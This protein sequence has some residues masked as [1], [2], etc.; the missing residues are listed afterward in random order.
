MYIAPHLT[1]VITNK[2][3][4]WIGAWYFGWVFIA[5]V[6]SSFSVIMALFPKELPRAAVRRRIATEKERRKNAS[7]LDL[8]EKDV[9][10]ETS[11]KDFFLTFKRLLKN[12]LYMYNNLA[13]TFYVFGFMPFWIFSPKLI[14]TLF[15]QSSSASSLFTG[16]F[17]LVASA[18]GILV[19]GFVITKFK[20]RARY[21]AL[22]NVIVGLLSVLSIVSFSFMGCDE[23]KNAVKMSYDD[24]PMCNSDC[25]CDFVRYSP[26]CGLDGITYISGCHAGCSKVSMFNSSRTFSQ[27][28]CVEAVVHHEFKQTAKTGPCP[29]DC[30]SQLI[31]FLSV[32]CFMKFLGASGRASNFLVGIRCVEERDKTLAIG[33]GMSVVRLL[34]A[35]PSPIFFGYILDTA[36][37]VWGKT[38]TSKGNCWLYDGDKLRSWFFYTSASAI[39]F[40]TIFDYLVWKNAKNLKIFDDKDEEKNV[41]EEKEREEK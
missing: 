26:V 7:K 12:K 30:K 16:T 25:H 21:L 6:L 33:F 2:D 39:A 15:R 17:A 4:R 8:A 20:P 29:I 31:V 28:S 5:L 9:E 13:G 27:C 10:P 37:L 11:L 34:A 14:E 23:S 24:V 22:W 40:G 41:K 36:C 32:M 1:P 19:A 35:V 38:C 18:V 3:P